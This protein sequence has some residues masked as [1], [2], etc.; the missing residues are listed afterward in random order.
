MSNEVGNPFF[1]AKPFWRGKE[2]IAVAEFRSERREW[3]EAF[4]VFSPA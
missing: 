2:A 1:C 3:P 4:F